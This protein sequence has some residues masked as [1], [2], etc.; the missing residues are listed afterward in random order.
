[1]ENL[2]SGNYLEIFEFIKAC[3][4]SFLPS[5]LPIV[6]RR[7]HLPYT[8]DE[9]EFRMWRRSWYAEFNLVYDR[10]TKFG[11]QTPN[12][13]IENILMSLPLTCSW[14]FD[15]QPK[16]NKEKW[17]MEVLKTPVDWVN[18]PLAKM[19]ELLVKYSRMPYFSLI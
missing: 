11:L 1:M 7:W 8:E 6:N 4:D 12:A 17:I 16:N 2:N 10:G 9:V 5:Y 3:G 13:E 15:Y 18:H 19:S 14:K